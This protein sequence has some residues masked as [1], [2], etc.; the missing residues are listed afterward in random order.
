MESKHLHDL[1]RVKAGAWRV[2]QRHSLHYAN[3]LVVYNWQ[4]LCYNNHVN[5]FC[6]LFTSHAND[7]PVGQ[8]AN[9]T[10]ICYD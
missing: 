9:N 5:W 3:N 6:G 4:F 8:V 2:A 10:T 7:C 1:H